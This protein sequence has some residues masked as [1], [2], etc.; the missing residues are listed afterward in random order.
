M[1][2]RNERL[3]TEEEDRHEKHIKEALKVCGYLSWTMRKVKEQ[4]QENNSKTWEERGE[5]KDQRRSCTGSL[6]SY[7]QGHA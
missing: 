2:D 7:R 3:V 6:R 4:R 1:I 5:G